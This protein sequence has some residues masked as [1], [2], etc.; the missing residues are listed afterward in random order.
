MTLG[1]HEMTTDGDEGLAHANATLGLTKELHCD[2]IHALTDDGNAWQV[3]AGWTSGAR[4][5]MR[6]S[7][8]SAR[9]RGA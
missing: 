6:S 9:A 5:D 2:G 1:L 8:E 7:Q 3:R 4:R